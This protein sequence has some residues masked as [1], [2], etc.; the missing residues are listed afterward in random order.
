VLVVL[1]RHAHSELN[2]ERRV[3]GD[4]SRPVHITGEGEEEARLLGRQLANVVFDRCL[5][6]R[7]GR[8]Q[9]TATLAL[10]GRDVPVEVEPLLDDIDVGELEGVSLDD[11]RAWKRQHARADPFPGGE[12]LDDA[13]RRY[14]EAYRKLL[15]RGRHSVLVVC[16]EIPIR[17]A[18][19]AAA[20]A[21]DLDAPVHEIPNAT[22]F[23]FDEVSLAR[24][25]ERIEALSRPR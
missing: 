1:A 16:H 20:G 4:P 7:F 10:A 17:Y 8:T 12:S 19:N 22:P 25:A 14:V 11:Y 21:A 23:L 5:C 24:A 2:V 15:S 6:T 18:L 9:E 13:A 3:N